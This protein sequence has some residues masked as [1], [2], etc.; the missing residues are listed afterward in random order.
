M[1]LHRRVSALEAATTR[2]Y[3]HRTPEEQAEKEQRFAVL[4][5]ELEELGVDV[6]ESSEDPFTELFQM[7]EECRREADGESRA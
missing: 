7:I 3:T 6:E 4:Y 5:A 2:Q 1:S